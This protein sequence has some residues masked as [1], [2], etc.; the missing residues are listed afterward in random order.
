MTTPTPKCRNCHRVVKTR[1]YCM[2]CYKLALGTGEIAYI[3]GPRK[4]CDTPTPTC[5]CHTCVMR[6]M[7]A[8]VEDQA[9]R[10]VVIESRWDVRCMLC[11]W[12]VELGAA[13]AKEYS[14]RR[15]ICPRCMSGGLLYDIVLPTESRVRRVSA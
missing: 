6:R 5:E 14:I 13:D 15:A 7:D 10:S 8:A 4:G 1:G 11:G 2:R 9:N 12:S 3:R